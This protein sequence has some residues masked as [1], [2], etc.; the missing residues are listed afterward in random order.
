MVAELIDERLSLG[1]SVSQWDNAPMLRDL[2]RRWIDV[3]AEL[4][5][6]ALNDYEEQQDIEAAVGE[7]LDR[8]GYKF[9]VERPLS[10]STD[11]PFFGFAGTAQRG[12]DQARFWDSDPATRGQ[13]PIGDPGFRPLVKLAGRGVHTDCSVSDISGL[14]RQSVAGAYIYDNADGTAHVVFDDARVATRYITR[15]GGIELKEGRR[16]TYD[17]DTAFTNLTL[18]HTAIASDESNLYTIEVDAP[19]ARCVVRTLD[20]IETR[21]FSLGERS[22]SNTT[23]AEVVGDTLYVTDTSPSHRLTSYDIPTG[24]AGI[25]VSLGTLTPQGVCYDIDRGVLYISGRSG[26]LH[27]YTLEGVATAPNDVAV[28]ETDIACLAYAGR[29]IRVGRTG[30]QVVGY[31][32]DGASDKDIE[33]TGIA[34]QVDMTA[35]SH[36]LY[37]GNGTSVTRFQSR[38]TD[39]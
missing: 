2:I 4:E 28:S 1:L 5:T 35:T 22:V 24:N 9:G 15:P 18:E 20:G 12:F 3:I 31:A 30:G 34:S 8:I 37:I 33:F 17:A 10:D 23:G 29:R 16:G 6:D 11:E 21:R 27:A 36:Y 39:Y 14:T 26:P 32:N 25:D 38:I 13:V 7:H 19:T